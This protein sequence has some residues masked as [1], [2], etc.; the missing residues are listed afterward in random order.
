MEAFFDK[1]SYNVF[2]GTHFWEKNEPRANFF[3]LIVLEISFVKPYVMK[4]PQIVH[5][6]KMA[7]GT[8]K[9]GAFWHVFYFRLKRSLDE[10]HTH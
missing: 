6:Q 9:S 4:K 7:A 2:Y 10:I 3:G 1:S 5:I 8:G